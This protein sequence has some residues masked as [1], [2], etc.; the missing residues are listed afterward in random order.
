MVGIEGKSFTLLN[1]YK[2]E[3]EKMDFL[4][5]VYQAKVRRLTTSDVDQ[6]CRSC[7]CD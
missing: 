4:L 3:I 1:R 7:C 5:H 2:T 6:G